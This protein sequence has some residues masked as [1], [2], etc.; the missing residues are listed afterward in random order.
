[1]RNCHS[2]RRDSSQT[3]SPR[4]H[5][6]WS[7]PNWILQQFAQRGGTNRHMRAS[8]AWDRNP[9]IR[10]HFMWFWKSSADSTAQDAY[11]SAERLQK[12]SLGL[13]QIA[14]PPRQ[15]PL[16]SK[17]DAGDKKMCGHPVDN[18][19]HIWRRNLAEIKPKNGAF[20]CREWW[21]VRRRMGTYTF[22]PRVEFIRLLWNA[23]PW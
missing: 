13:P 2:S 5:C 23:A 14:Q 20:W 12:T 4:T 8:N 16:N 19:S 9:D 3:P 10:N 15:P 18:R 11:S 17:K 1:M 6:N 7:T 22:L 21:C